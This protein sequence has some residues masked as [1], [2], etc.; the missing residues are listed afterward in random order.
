MDHVPVAVDH[1]RGGVPE[2][3]DGLRERT[4]LHGGVR[5]EL[6]GLRAF[7]REE[8]LDVGRHEV[9]GDRDP[10]PEPVLQLDVTVVVDPEDAGGDGEQD[11]RPHD[12]RPSGI[13]P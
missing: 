6:H 7:P 9:G 2:R 3:R 11:E 12:E 13:P 8:V 4:G 1:H 5:E 10:Q